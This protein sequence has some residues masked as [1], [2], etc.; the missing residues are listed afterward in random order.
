MKRRRIGLKS[1]AEGFFFSREAKLT[2]VRP[3]VAV[4]VLLSGSCSRSSCS[5]II[6]GGK[7]GFLSEGSR[8]HPPRLHQSNLSTWPQHLS[9]HKSAGSPWHSC[10]FVIFFPSTK[11]HV[12]NIAP[13]FFLFCYF[14][15]AACLTR[16]DVPL[17]KHLQL[18]ASLSG[19]CHTHPSRLLQAGFLVISDFRS[20]SSEAAL[21]A[22]PLSDH[23][24][25]I[26]RLLSRR[27][28][29]IQTGRGSLTLS[30]SPS[31]KVKNSR[32]DQ[33]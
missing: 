17:W 1:S 27:S 6:Y 12:A 32:V 29:G 7:S 15:F 30:L 26:T 9:T 18:D 24:R 3:T 4:N 10:V 31:T 13:F 33:C 2:F 23:S 20:F 25:C 11:S 21:P 14:S 28:T 5:Q 22:P 16:P 19:A 8:G